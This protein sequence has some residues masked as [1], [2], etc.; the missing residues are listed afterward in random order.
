MAS[1]WSRSG[2]PTPCGSKES[3]FAEPHDLA[4][5]LLRAYRPPLAD[6]IEWTFP[7][8]YKRYGFTRR[9]AEGRAVNEVAKGRRYG[10][11][12]FA[13]LL[14][15]TPAAGATATGERLARNVSGDARDAVGVAETIRRMMAESLL[16]GYASRDEAYVTVSVGVAIFPEH[17]GSAFE[18]VV[19]ADKALYLA[20]RMG[21]D[22]VRYSTRARNSGRLG[23]TRAAAR[24]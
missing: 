10:G 12:A 2:I 21:K 17:A 5:F 1:R 6:Q 13:V 11:E 19:N 22:C 14:P 4:G 16:E 8:E 20:K 23:I 18:L 9:L 7:V 3:W 15:S 24:V